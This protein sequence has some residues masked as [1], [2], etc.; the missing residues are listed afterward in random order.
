MQTAIERITE[1]ASQIASGGD[2]IVPGEAVRLSDAAVAG[3]TVRQGDLYLV[4]V[5]G[6]VEG[7]SKPA[8][9][10]VPGNTEGAKHCLDS[11]EGVSMRFPEGWGPEHAGLQGPVFHCK[12]ER[13][14]CHPKHGDVTI[15]AGFT[16]AAHYQREWD[17][18]QRAERRNAD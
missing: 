11:L 1:R 16:V 5:D 18:E 10:L 4:V 17:Q 3:D 13:T 14:V 7:G 9:Q 6:P 2:K 8:R 12:E 15:P